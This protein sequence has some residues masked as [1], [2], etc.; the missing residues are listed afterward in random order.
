MKDGLDVSLLESQ[1]KIVKG[2]AKVAIFSSVTSVIVLVHGFIIPDPVIFLSIVLIPIA[3]VMADN[4]IENMYQK[5]I[6]Y[7]LND[8]QARE[9]S[10][11]EIMD[12]SSDKKASNY[13][14]SE[15]LRVR[16][17]DEKGPAFGKSDKN[18]STHGKRI[19]AM[20]N[21]DYDD[22]ESISTDTENMIRDADNIQSEISAKQWQQ[23]ESMDSDLIEA[24]VENLGDLIKTGWFE[25]NKQDDAVKRLHDK[26]E[27][28]QI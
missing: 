16:G 13:P 14:N 21:R 5:K 22:I 24:G 27:G 15:Y 1:A 25:K 18:F 19:D 26:Y 2:L 4:S 11:K 10:D 7:L 8:L 20:T 28:N 23:S 12:N 17:G 9:F 3:I 6:E